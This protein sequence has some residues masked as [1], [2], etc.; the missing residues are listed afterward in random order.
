MLTSILPNAPLMSGIIGGRPPMVV[1]FLSAD[2]VPMTVFEHM[3]RT[4]APYCVEGNKPV[5]CLDVAG[6]VT[7]VYAQILV[8][9]TFRYMVRYLGTHVIPVQLTVAPV[10][11]TPLTANT[12]IGGQV[13]AFTFTVKLQV[14]ALPAASAAVYMTVVGVGDTI[15][16]EPDA[17]RLLRLINAASVQLSNVVA[18]KV[19]VPVQE[20]EAFVTVILLGQMMPGASLSSTVTVKL[21][22][23]VMS[24]SLVTTYSTV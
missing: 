18:V 5:S 10:L 22:A 9:A 20:P 23:S 8:V 16:S 12:L 2:R 11:V 4:R 6:A 7:S 24:S 19:A 14:V 17:G 21:Q 3:V 13:V 1:N 15:N